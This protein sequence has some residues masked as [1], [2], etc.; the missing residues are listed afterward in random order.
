MLQLDA[1]RHAGGWDSIDDEELAR[2]VRDW[3]DAHPDGW[4]CDGNYSAVREQVVARAEGLVFLDLP[5]RI[6]L[7][8]LVVRSFDRSWSGRPVYGPGSARESFRMLFGSQSIL[9]Y[10]LTT[11]H[12][13]RRQRRGWA[14]AL[15]A[16]MS[17]HILESPSEVSRFLEALPIRNEAELALKPRA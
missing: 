11:F 12:R 5:L 2:K 1:V 17:V 16:E 10:A 14:E 15:R 4:V 9:L 8:R 3:L 6:T 7:P 13:K